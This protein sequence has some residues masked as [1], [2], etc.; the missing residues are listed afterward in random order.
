MEHKVEEICLADIGVGVD[1]KVKTQPQ[2][3]SVELLTSY[4]WVDQ[5]I[6]TILVPGKSLIIHTISQHTTN[7]HSQ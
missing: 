7:T 5:D 4:N 3:E 2:I 6:P 1:V